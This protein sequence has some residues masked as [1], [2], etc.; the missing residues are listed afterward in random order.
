MKKILFLFLF[1]V[2]GIGST[3]WDYEFWNYKTVRTT[4]CIFELQSSTWWLI[5]SKTL[6]AC[7]NNTS[8]TWSSTYTFVNTWDW[9][10][11]VW[12]T[13]KY[14]NSWVDSYGWLFLFFYNGSTWSEKSYKNPYSAMP[15]N[16]SNYLTYDWT[17]G[18]YFRTR[19][20]ISWDTILFNYWN[21]NS[22][23]FN[24]TTTVLTDTSYTYTP[25]LNQ[26]PT[27]IQFMEQNYLYGSFAPDPLEITGTWA[28][29]YLSN[30]VEITW[31][32]A[33]VDLEVD[34]VLTKYNPVPLAN[35]VYTWSLWSFSWGTLTLNI[36]N[37]GSLEFV[38]LWDYILTL[39]FNDINYPPDKITE[40]LAFDY[41]YNGGYVDPNTLE[42][43][44]STSWYAFNDRGFWLWN[45][46]PEPYGGDLQFKIIQPNGTGTT[47]VFTQLYWPVETDGLG[48]GFSTAV[49]VEYPY[50][51]VS[52]VYQVTPIY[53][54]NGVTVYPFWEDG[55]SYTITAPEIPYEPVPLENSCDYDSSGAV[56]YDEII[57]CVWKSIWNFTTSTGNFFKNIKWFFETL[58]E[59]WN[60]TEEKEFWLLEFFIPSANAYASDMFDQGPE[61]MGF[62][63]KVYNYFKYFLILILI[64]GIISLFIKKKQW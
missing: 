8:Y 43:S 32:S 12:V 1:F 23:S 39:N 37:T 40:Y 19:F 59:I 42:Y 57:S 22:A 41:Q 63:G 54:Y 27:W 15:N 49:K 53:I 60:T 11:L 6:S 44:F 26:Y 58:A 55:N 64:I 9:N 31:F 36:T 62:L 51:P 48:Y 30:G 16:W 29:E 46:I 13:N 34:Y 56:S 35:N 17:Y 45:F 21:Q 24:K 7:T 4:P 28:I 25:S 38:N 20:Y 10:I 14:S 61:D 18:Y 52:W 3:F 50:H 5:Y 33:N 47:E 2:F